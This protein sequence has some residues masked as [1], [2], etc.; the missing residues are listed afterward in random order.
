MGLILCESAVSLICK[1]TILQ[2]ISSDSE[3][4]RNDKSYVVQ[5]EGF[6]CGLSV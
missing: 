2:Q 5:T 3:V 4:T 1:V 6:C